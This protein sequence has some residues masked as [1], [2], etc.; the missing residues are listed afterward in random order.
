MLSMIYIYP[1]T[2]VDKRTCNSLWTAN[3]RHKSD[4][5]ENLTIKLTFHKINDNLST[6]THNKDNIEEQSENNT[7]IHKINPLTDIIESR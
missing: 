7:N 1:S 6:K 2:Q 4:K 5:T 3:D